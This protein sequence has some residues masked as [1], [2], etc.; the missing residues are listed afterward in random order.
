MARL[1]N[2]EVER[3]KKPGRY[4]DGG[5][6]Y[7]Q[8][9]ST[10]TKS[11]AFRY[12]ITIGGKKQDRQMG[13]GPYP[14]ISLADARQRAITAKRSLVDGV[15]PI[16]DRKA[17]RAAGESKPTF[18]RCA[19]ECIE[20]MRPGWKSKKHAGQW[21]ST[22][23][24]YAFSTMG[25]L[26]V[27]EIETRHVLE[28][29]RPLWVE[30]APTASRLRGRIEAVLDWA[31]AN[32]HRSSENPARWRGHLD[33]LLAKPGALRQV[34]H[35]SAL[36]IAEMGA[37]MR[38]LREREGMGA[39][40]LEFAILTAARSGEVRGADWSEIDMDRE[41]WTIP[42]ERMKAKREHQVP[43][44]KNAIEILRAIR[45]IQSQRLVFPSSKAGRPLS[46]MTLS[47]VLRRMGLPGITVHGFRS[48]FRDW[49]GDQT[50]FPSEVAEAA[51]AHTIRDKT[52]AAYRRGTAIE[53][54][55]KLMEAWANFCAV[56]EEGNSN[57][58]NLS[59]RMGS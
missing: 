8:V 55:R 51:L 50:N 1:K 27:D 14:A 21:R 35:H 30:K 26:P 39:R 56:G 5:G 18:E 16:E 53:K 52:E 23:K 19:T 20:A 24:A 34:K 37:F 36:P 58:V 7:L 41:L 48:T 31:A 47:A 25:S 11:W 44:S 4:G 9:S 59:N 15:D 32:S 46:D 43:L 42:V 10:G 2:L 38:E 40:A 49:V 57:I 29:L 33:K 22:L 45:E 12:R 54:R 3:L 6:L 17:R 13:L 28:V